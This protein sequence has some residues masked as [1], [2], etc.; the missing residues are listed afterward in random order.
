MQIMSFENI[1]RR[2][3]QD[4]NNT[5]WWMYVPAITITELLQEPEIAYMQI[6]HIALYE[7]QQSWLESLL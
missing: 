4:N 3:K 2:C 1:I 7:R 5:M 6:K